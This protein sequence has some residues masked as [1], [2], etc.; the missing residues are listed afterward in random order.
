MKRPSLRFF[1]LAVFVALVAVIV[2][3]RSC[4]WA[5]SSSLQ[6][7][8]VL[9]RRPY[10]QDGTPTSVVI[11]WRT[12][13]PTSTRVRYGTSLGALSLNADQSTMT[14]EHVMAVSNLVSSTRYYYSVGSTEMEIEGDDEGHS[15]VTAPAP[16]SAVPTRIWVIGDSGTAN[17]DARRVRDA[18]YAYPGAMQTNVWLM[19]G[20]NAYESGR[21][22][23]YQKAVFDMYPAMLS[24]S[25][26]WPTIG[27]H[28]TAQS[29]NAPATLPYFEMF[30]L[31]TGGE[32]GGMASGTE[33]YYSFDYG[34][35]H[36]VCL[37][38]MT[39]VDRVPVR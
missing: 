28:D 25:V 2:S 13:V 27:N 18:Y 30:S 7:S 26:L 21:D 11:R 37:D 19:L 5:Q 1:L 33:R 10:L 23:E 29:Q 6:D 16:G 9:T 14:T 39:S 4:L 17:N 32:A 36:F 20:D 38:S 8:F 35:I 3:A 34:N 31:P 22:S 12:N 24:R 15:F